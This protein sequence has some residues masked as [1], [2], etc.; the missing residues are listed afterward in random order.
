MLFRHNVHR[1]RRYS[2]ALAMPHA[3]YTLWNNAHFLSLILSSPF[4]HR[5]MLQQVY[6]VLSTC[7]F[8]ALR[9]ANSTVRINA[10]Y[11]N[12]MYFERDWCKLIKKREI[13][14]IIVRIEEEI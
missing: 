14:L 12:S 13:T 2:P 8:C 9:S 5:T 6:R 4:H 10:Q 1:D 7:Q 11:N 3:R